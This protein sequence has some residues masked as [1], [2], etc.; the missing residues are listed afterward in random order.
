[1][2]SLS[3]I[4][5]YAT[6][7]GA[8]VVSFLSP[9]VLPLVPAYLSFMAG[10]TFEELTA[11]G[12]KRIAV[13]KVVVPATAFVFGFAIVFMLLGASASVLHKLIFEHLDLISKVAGALIILFGL[14]F[15]GAF[16]LSVFNL[17]ARF[18]LP[19]LGAGPVPAFVFGLAFAFGW[20]PCLS[21]ILSTILALAATEE[22]IGRGVALLG[23]YATGLGV[24]FVAAALAIRPFMAFAARYRRYMR[25]TE[26]ITG[27][28]L[29]ATG[30]L[31][32]FNAFT[33]IAGW[34]IEVFPALEKLG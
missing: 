18:H 12:Q 17:E 22:S 10:A 8:G 20:T 2:T 16:R 15:A 24:P 5:P 6:A 1:M 13:E 23:I 3:L 14:N 21:P 25:A 11:A 32:F 33:L 29:V 27:L 30:T 4:L 26:V 9:C 7:A 28:M 31:I 34:I 19:K